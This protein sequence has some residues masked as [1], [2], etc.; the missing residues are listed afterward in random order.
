MMILDKFLFGRSKRQ[1]PS[2]TTIFT[3]PAAGAAMQ[4]IE[5][6]QAIKNRGLL[7][8]RY[9]KETGHWQSI[10]ACQVTLISDHDLRHMQKY[11]KAQ[12]GEGQHRRN[13]IVAGIKTQKL[14][15]KRFLIGDALFA[16]HKQRPP[17]AYIDSITEPWMSKT[18]GLHAGVCLHV[19]E[20]GLIQV[21]DPLTIVADV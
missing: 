20:S 10:E 19:L 4:S 14:E 11:G 12:V 5:A 1:T 17:C 13:L 3:S 9:F 21:G 7:G 18:L 6:V 8:D 2:L 16:W 15:N